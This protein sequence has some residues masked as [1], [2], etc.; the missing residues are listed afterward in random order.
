MLGALTISPLPPLHLP[1]RLR[2]NRL[3]P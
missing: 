3:P 2:P 1:N